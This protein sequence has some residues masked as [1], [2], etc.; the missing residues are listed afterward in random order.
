MMPFEV[1]MG[2]LPKAHSKKKCCVSFSKRTEAAQE[3]FGTLAV[4]LE[5]VFATA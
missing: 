2:R 3:I 5:G 4:Q 1:W